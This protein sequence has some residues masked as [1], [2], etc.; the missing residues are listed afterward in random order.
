[1]NKE[2]NKD[3]NKNKYVV[4]LL[5]IKSK[6]ENYNTINSYRMVFNLIYAKSKEEAFGIQ[7]DNH[8]EEFNGFTFVCYAAV[9]V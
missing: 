5:F 9:Q 3:E 6:I 2:I 4:T 1:M 7:Y 8:I